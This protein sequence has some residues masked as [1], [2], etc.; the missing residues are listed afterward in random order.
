MVGKA[1]EVQRSLSAL[2]IGQQAIFNAGLTCNLALAA[3]D[4]YSGRMTPGDFVLVQSLFMQLAGPLFNLGTF[5]RQL[6]ETSVDV[7]DLYHNINSKPMV[8][9]KPNA[10]EFVYKEGKIKFENLHFKH[11]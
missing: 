1:M 9:E 3:V 2:N 4:V 7:E 11:Y 8:T 10:K 5:L 6:E